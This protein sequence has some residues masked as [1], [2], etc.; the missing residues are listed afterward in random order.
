MS[1]FALGIFKSTQAHLSL[2]WTDF[3]YSA[4]AFLL[5][6]FF[7]FWCFFL[8]C[9][10]WYYA[11]CLLK[12]CYN[13]TILNFGI[14]VRVKSDV[15]TVDWIVCFL[16]ACARIASIKPARTACIGFILAWKWHLRVL[17]VLSVKKIVVL[18]WYWFFIVFTE[19]AM[20]IL[21]VIV[22]YEENGWT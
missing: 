11:L 8:F 4:F 10:S 21:G 18:L 16:F 19:F 6:L 14:S 1:V 2:C 12:C 15:V 13:P 22:R 7:V 9:A 17:Y 20:F 5:L 3:V